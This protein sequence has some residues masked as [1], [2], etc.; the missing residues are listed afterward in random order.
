M[1][2]TWVSRVVVHVVIRRLE[3][4]RNGSNRTLDGANRSQ[5]PR[6]RSRLNCP[7]PAWGTV[8]PRDGRVSARGP[9]TGGPGHHC[10]RVPAHRRRAAAPDMNDSLAA[11]SVFTAYVVLIAAALTATQIHGVNNE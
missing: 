4:T 5:N 8:D 7:E 3:T 9:G 10:A 2:R 6:K 1:T 11:R